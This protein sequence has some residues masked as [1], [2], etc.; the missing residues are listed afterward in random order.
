M[1]V[2][3]PSLIRGGGGVDTGG[4]TDQAPDTARFRPVSGTMVTTTGT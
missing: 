2:H 3:V 4:D 1:I